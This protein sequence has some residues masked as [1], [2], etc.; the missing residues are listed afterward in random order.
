MSVRWERYYPFLI[1]ALIFLVLVFTRPP[2]DVRPVLVT[3]ITIASIALGFL[4]TLAAVLL[5]INSNA[6]AFLRQIGKFG[7][8]LDYIWAGVH[9]TFFLTLASFV[10]QFVDCNHWFINAAWLALVAVA[11]LTTFRAIDIS[12]K[13]LRS[14]AHKE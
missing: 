5:S 3:A 8:I 11:L 12:T 6:I 7:D 14:E 13:I 9:W 2:I 10:L 4:G 1:G